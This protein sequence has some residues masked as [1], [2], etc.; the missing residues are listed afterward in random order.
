[1]FVSSKKGF[2]L[3]REVRKNRLG[4]FEERKKRKTQ[5]EASAVKTSTIVTKHAKLQIP[6]IILK[7]FVFSNLT[8]G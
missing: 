3:T 1:M 2:K 8:Q 6:T 5:K 4:R 7:L